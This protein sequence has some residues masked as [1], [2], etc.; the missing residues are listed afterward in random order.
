MIL[1][2]IQLY[3]TH[4]QFDLFVIPSLALS[5]YCITA[6][7]EYLTRFYADW[8]PPNIWRMIRSGLTLFSFLAVLYHGSCARN[9]TIEN[10]TGDSETGLLPTYEPVDILGMW[11]TY[12]YRPQ[13]GDTNPYNITSPVSVN[14][15]VF[16]EVSG[17]SRL[18]LLFHGQS[19]YFFIFT[20][21][22]N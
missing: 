21:V 15:T 6:T 9:V 18:T 4:W 14:T 16:T 2:V 11:S 12:G 8:S 19:F 17:V 22:W 5:R 13:Y 1:R 7:Y 10:D 20:N 3:V